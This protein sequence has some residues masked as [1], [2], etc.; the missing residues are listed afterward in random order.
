LPHLS[1]INVLMAL[2]DPR[3]QQHG[4]AKR[5][6]AQVSAPSSVGL[7]RVTQ[8]G[9]LRLLNN[10]AVM[11]QGVLTAVEAWAAVDLIAS[12]E[13]FV[14]HA[15]PAGLETLLRGHM[16]RAKHSPKI[17]SDA[18]LA[19]FAQTLGLTLVTFDRGFGEFAGLNY[20]LLGGQD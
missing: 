8:L 3:H 13:R 18:Y 16:E 14:F 5:W 12:D 10:P 20:L 7:C 2:C 17:W 11:R 19:A 15:E 9:L 4:A 6:M 1:D